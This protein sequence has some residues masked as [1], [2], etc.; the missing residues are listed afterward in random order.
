M[1]LLH[2]L[3]L[4]LLL[5]PPQTFKVNQC[6][7]GQTPSLA[8]A[9]SPRRLYTILSVAAGEKASFGNAAH[10]RAG[11]TVLPAPQVCA[12]AD[13]LTRIRPPSESELPLL[14]NKALIGMVSPSLNGD[15]SSRGIGR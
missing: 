14:A 15:V 11:A 10:L 13:L 2:L 9:F 8:R 12:A 6:F 1:G 7:R 3:L 4:L 5:L